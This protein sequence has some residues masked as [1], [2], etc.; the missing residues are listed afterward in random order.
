[1]QASAN[2]RRQVDND[3]IMHTDKN[4]ENARNQKRRK[5][6]YSNTIT[7]IQWYKKART[8]EHKSPI[9]QDHNNTITQKKQ[10]EYKT[11]RHKN[12]IPQ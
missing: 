1:M 7:M 5:Q 3:I 6:L 11:K 12:T 8:Q 2:A 10:H 9:Q 4:P